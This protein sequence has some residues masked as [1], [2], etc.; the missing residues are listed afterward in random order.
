MNVK[1]ALITALLI[2]PVFPLN[3]WSS[4]SPL[5]VTG[6]VRQ[7]LSLYL[8][9]LAGF[10]P[11]TVRTN[12]IRKDGTYHGVFITQGVP[13]KTL[14]DIASIRKEGAGFSKSLDL[15]IVVRNKEG[16]EVT[17]SWGEVFYR[18]PGDVT[19]AFAA[20]PVIPHKECKGCHEP[21]F[22]QPYMDQ[23][24]RKIELPKLIVAGDFD[25]DRSLEGI[26]NIEVV[27]LDP[28]SV[29]KKKAELV[30]R[31]I[32]ITGAVKKGLTFTDLASLPRV[33]VTMN[34]VGD[35]RGFHGRDEF[36]GVPLVELLS[37]AGVEQDLQS[38]FVVSA[39][40]GYRSLIS[41]GELFLSPQGRR[42]I[43]ADKANGQP[44]K[45]NGKFLLVV[46]DD[47][48]ADREVKAVDR[49]EAYTFHQPAKIYIIGMGP[50]DTDLITREAVSC[51]GRTDAVV[52]PEELS[53]VF[54]S[55]LAGKPILFDSMELIHRKFY[56][57]AHPEIPAAEL[58]AKFAQ[59]R[60]NG[61]EKIR[62]V[63]ARGQ[64]VAFLDWGD[65]LIFGSSR[66]IRNYFKDAEIETVASLSA[67]NVSNA[68]LGRDVTCNG[69]LVLT[70]PNG[71]RKN[72]A[73][74]KAAADNGDTVVIFIGLR[75]FRDLMPIFL[76]HF[77]E[78]TPVAIVYN[79]GISG[80]EHKV[81]G[82]LKDI[83]GKTAK[84]QEEFLG[85]IY[86]GPCLE[87][88]GGECH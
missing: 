72:E 47:L 67:F 22:S 84:E 88:K 28:N 39:P 11:A 19:I 20:T 23:L 15:A 31:Q 56:A 41:Y 79:A 58:D 68:I 65:P 82:T 80:A 74:L 87:E 53:K 1:K 34:V 54:E 59:A 17:L 75:E 70:V 6:L 8:S 36:E 13:L 40:D 64:N 5:T 49:I 21:G 52:A 85:M 83:L 71:I 50:G 35:G 3:G 43:I 14:L 25:S 4:Q 32:S 61:V 30:S 60:K 27:N 62:E 77:K 7:P 16:K 86:V 51:L 45:K 33:G 46:P 12:D 63:L 66:W 24:N 26:V 42:I 76:K 48:A 57:K 69:S 2:L 18:N 37:R 10:Q 55:F 73:M 38:V 78:T 81:A 44:L 29:N 9:D